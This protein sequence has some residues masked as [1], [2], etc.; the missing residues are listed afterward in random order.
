MDFD[1]EMFDCCWLF[2]LFAKSPLLGLAHSYC[3]GQ[4]YQMTLLDY[5]N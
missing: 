5:R 4:L 2:R 1:S 3:Q